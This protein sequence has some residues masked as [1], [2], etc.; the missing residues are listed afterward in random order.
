YYSIIGIDSCDLYADTMN[1]ARTVYL[2][3]EPNTDRTNS[4][5][6]NA[7][8]GWLGGV[9]AY[10]IYRSYNGP[11]V[12]V[13]TVPASQL[14][15][16]DSIEDII[17][18]EGKFCYYVEAVEGI[19]TPVGPVVAP[20]SPILFEELSRS[21]EACAQQHPNVFMPNA[22]MPDGINRIF[23][24]VSIYVQ[25]NTYLFQIYNRWGQRLFET[26]NP[27]EGW[28]G[29]YGGK[30]AA[31]GAYVY[32]VQFVSSDGQTYSKNGSVTLIR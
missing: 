27:E 26:N 15:Y 17:I 19:G 18:G 11:F 12:A 20:P 32:Y 21:N 2:E 6:W 9:T 23:K 16:L 7:Y 10:N 1:M 24:P 8:E 4:L 25:A 13:A 14:T 3:V 5:Q 22:F 30:K 28:D 31:Q 29:S